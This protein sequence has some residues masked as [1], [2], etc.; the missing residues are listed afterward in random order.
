MRIETFR[1]LQILATFPL[2]N[3]GNHFPTDSL[4]IPDLFT[5]AKE[6]GSWSWGELNGVVDGF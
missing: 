6:K 4:Q 1:N 3:I 5:G 2:A